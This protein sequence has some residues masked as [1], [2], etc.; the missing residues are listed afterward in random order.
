MLPACLPPRSIA[1][2]RRAAPDQA[3][4]EPCSTET[5]VNEESHSPH[6]LVTDTRGFWRYAHHGWRVVQS[7][8]KGGVMGPGVTGCVGSGVPPPWLARRR[9][10][11]ALT[12]PAGARR[13]CGSP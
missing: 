6:S 5:R 9:G 2:R 4:L 8:P 1:P 13:G 3:I 10:A 12:R 7:P 11:L